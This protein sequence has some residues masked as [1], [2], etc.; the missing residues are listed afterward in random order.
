M[1]KALSASTRASEFF[2]CSYKILALVRM[3]FAVFKELFPSSWTSPEIDKA[4]LMYYSA[5]SCSPF[6]LAF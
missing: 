3:K 6:L 1:D 5:F 4:L 2:F